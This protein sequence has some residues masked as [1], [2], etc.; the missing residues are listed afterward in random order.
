MLSAR[1]LLVMARRTAGLSQAELALRLGRP[2]WTVARWELGEMEPSYDSVMNTLAACGLSA[3]MALAPAD[4]S[5]QYDV[6]MPLRLTPSQRLEQL[7]GLERLSLL[8]EIAAVAP[9]SIVIGDTAGALSGWPLIL[10]PDDAIEICPAPP[11][12]DALSAVAIVAEPRVAARVARPAPRRARAAC[13]RR[14]R[15]CRLAAGSAALERARGQ[16]IQALR[17]EA[18]VE[19]ARRWPHRPPAAREYSDAE[20]RATS[21][22]G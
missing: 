20:A 7:G 22:R 19:Y 6:G 8:R 16:Q 21:M 9:A 11:D 2:T 4:A 15:A 1:D 14:P 17:M 13:R 5:H 18:V 10:P 12:R 3:T